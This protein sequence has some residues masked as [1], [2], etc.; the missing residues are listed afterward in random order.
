MGLAKT[1]ADAELDL[2]F[3]GM[4]QRHWVVTVIQLSKEPFLHPASLPAA[5]SPSPWLCAG[6]FVRLTV[7]SLV[8]AHK[9]GTFSDLP[10]L[11]TAV[12]IHLFPVRSPSVSV[13]LKAAC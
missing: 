7:L 11:R 9:E 3:A 5:C 4:P 8:T 1:E 13:E 12:P 2:V 6:P 10:P